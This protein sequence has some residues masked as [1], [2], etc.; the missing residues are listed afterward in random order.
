ML[1]VENGANVSRAVAGE[2]LISPAK[3]MRCEDDIVQLQD[4]IRGI[5]R[6]LL[7]HIKPGPSEAALLK[8]LRESPLV[9][10]GPPRGIDEVGGRLHQGQAFRVDKVMRLRGLTGN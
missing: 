4:W 1:D 9:D 10:N 7:K 3:R 6:L 5:R 2:A 8:R